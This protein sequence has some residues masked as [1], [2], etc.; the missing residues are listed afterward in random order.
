MAA[1]PPALPNIANHPYGVVLGGAQSVGGAG[2]S[3]TDVGNVNGTGFDSFVIGAPTVINQN[4]RIQPMSGGNSR[5]YLIFG[6]QN[7]NVGTINSIADWLTR[8]PNP[9]QRVGDLGQLGNFI[10]QNPIDGASNPG[11]SFDGITFMTGNTPGSQLGLS[12]AA[13]G[14]LANG[15]NGFII[16]A[17]GEPASDNTTPGTGRAYL[18]YGSPNF[19]NVPNKMIDLDNQALANLP[20]LGINIAAHVTNSVVGP[21]QPCTVL[22]L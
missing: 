18:I 9:D 13:V 12:V 8:L 19:D 10:Q 21:S 2:F 4:G 15:L 17:P 16:G 7:V 3:V 22:L 14:R 6:S 1:P 20:S 11:P 5:A